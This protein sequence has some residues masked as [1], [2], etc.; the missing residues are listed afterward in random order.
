MGIP[1][2]F[3]HLQSLAVPKTLGC[4]TDGC[5]EHPFGPTIIID[6]PSLAFYVNYRILAH[7]SPST[8]P[9]DAVPSYNEL[10]KATLAFL[11]EFQQHGLTMYEASQFIALELPLLSSTKTLI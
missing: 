2:M 10:G 9:I 5:T 1:R 8:N 3:S 11:D 4:K 7:R 6:G